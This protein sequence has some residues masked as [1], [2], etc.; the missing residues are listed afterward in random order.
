MTKLGVIF[1]AGVCGASA[2]ALALPPTL[3][4]QYT[5]N[6]TSI[7]PQLLFEVPEPTFSL[8]VLDPGS[9]SSIVG[10]A[11]FTPIS[12]YDPNPNVSFTGM[13]TGTGG[14]VTIEGAGGNSIT[15]Y[16]NP[17]SYPKLPYS[18]TATVIT[19]PFLP[20]PNQTVNAFY[21]MNAKDGVV[22]SVTFSG[23]NQ[24]TYGQTCSE[25]GTIAK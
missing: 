19:L 18:L 5:V 15:P 17:V 6:F 16:S 4:G 20:P 7:C 10:L 22:R 11:V 1:A 25:S 3:S 24:D 21:A 8:T 23:L 12:E 13:S 9:S 2:Q 14:L